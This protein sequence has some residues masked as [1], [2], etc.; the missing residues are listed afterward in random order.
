M[1]INLGCGPHS[2]DGWLNLDLEAHPGVIKCDLSLGK[3]PYLDDS[4]D[5]AFSEHFIEHITRPQFVNL[6]KDVRRVLK[7]GGVFRISTPNLSAIVEDYRNN[8]ID[9]W[10]A[11][12]L[13]ASSCDFLNEAMRLWGHQYLYDLSEL[14]KVYKE[15]GFTDLNGFRVVQYHK[16]DAAELSGLEKRPYHLDLIVEMKKESL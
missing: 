12:W 2:M 6:L 16:S 7:P 10:G 8:K 14:V 11:V 4:V 1:K 13:P 9:R 15:A 3:L 5:Y